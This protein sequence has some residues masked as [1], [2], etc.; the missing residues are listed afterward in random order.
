[1]HAVLL[2]K[3]SNKA[4]QESFKNKLEKIFETFIHKNQQPSPNS[5]YTSIWKVF[6]I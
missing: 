5:D 6:N 3:M 1:M 4:V 2:C